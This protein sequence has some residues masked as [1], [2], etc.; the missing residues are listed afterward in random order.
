M[1]IMQLSACL[2]AAFRGMPCV[3]DCVQFMASRWLVG[4]FGLSRKSRRQIDREGQQQSGDGVKRHQ[5][6]S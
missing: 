1:I 5:T 4:I 6:K 2:W 3:L